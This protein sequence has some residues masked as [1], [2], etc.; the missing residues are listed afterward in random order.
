MASSSNAGQQQDLQA[1]SLAASGS[2]SLFDFY[3][4]SR[5]RIFLSL[6]VTF[7]VISILYRTSIHNYLVFHSLIELFSIIVAGGIFTLAWNTRHFLENRYLLL[8]GIAYFFVGAQDLVHTLAYKGM[9]VFP[10]S[11]PDLATQLWISARYMESIS[12]FSAP[13][14]FNRKF[15]PEH[16]LTFYALIT[17]WLLL[18]IFSGIFPACFV[19]GAGLTPF[20]KTSEYV[21]SVILFSSFILL[22]KNRDRFET[23]IYRMLAASIFLTI[24]SELAFTIYI[25]VFG[26]SNMIG[27]LFKLASFYLVYKAILETGLKKPYDLLLRELKQREMLLRSS[28]NEFRSMFELSAVGMAQINPATHLFT[29]VNQKFCEITGYSADELRALTFSDITLP[30]DRERDLDQFNGIIRGEKEQMMSEKRYRRK[31]KTVIWVRMTATLIPFGYNKPARA[32]GIIED[33][34]ECKKTSRALEKTLGELKRSN[35]DLEEFAYV[36]SHD[37]QSPLRTVAGFVQLLDKRY[38]DQLDEKAKEFISIAKQGTTHMQNLLTD[39]LQYS[40]IGSGMRTLRPISLQDVLARTLVNLKSAIDESGATVNVGEMPTVQADEIQM[41]QVM[42]N[43]IGNSIKFRG[44]EP[45]VINISAEPG[46]GEWII[47]V[48]DNG[49]GMEPQYTDRIFQVFNRLHSQDKYEGTG[50]GLAICKKIIERQGGR[51]WVESEPNRGSI[52][53]FSIKAA[54]TGELRIPI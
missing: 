39:L 11:G 51:I 24:G 1:A 46:D 34:T 41:F 29:R 21:I 14:L 28:E 18:T 20:K 12:L 35:E 3:E 50:I 5:I 53:Y 48:Q 49:I 27:H 2:Q 45:P 54:D 13:L 43:L 9:W 47:R 42:Q 6:L 17:G 8:L 38:A 32:I 44:D 52:F 15:K 7:I 22:H 19:E 31:D 30:E 37:L 10:N 16:V 40:R 33:I 26:L 4:K 23:G 36:A 25:S